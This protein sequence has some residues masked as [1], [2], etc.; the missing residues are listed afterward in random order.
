MTA[1]PMTQVA[2]SG[3]YTTL[4]TALRNGTAPENIDM[5]EYDCYCD[6][7]DDSLECA[8]W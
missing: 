6:Q 5:D 1:N 7:E 2:P 8:Y 4:M 3:N